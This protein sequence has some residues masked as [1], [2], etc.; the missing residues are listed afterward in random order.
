MNGFGYVNRRACNQVD[1]KEPLNNV[2]EDANTRQKRAKKRSL[3]RVNEHFEYVFNAVVA[4]QVVIQRLLMLDSESD[5]VQ[6]VS[7]LFECISE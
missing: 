7:A 3:H 4:T 2:T 1:V 6:Y 5:T